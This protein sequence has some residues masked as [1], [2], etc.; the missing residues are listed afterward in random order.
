MPQF[1]DQGFTGVRADARGR[2]LGKW[3]KAA[4]LLHVREIYPGLQTVITGN[5]SSNG[6]MLAIN[7]AMGFKQHRAGNEYQISLKKL[8]EAGR[9][10]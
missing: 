6:P 9:R 1:I 4:M 3:L 5:A 10:K 2:G 8:R 7:K